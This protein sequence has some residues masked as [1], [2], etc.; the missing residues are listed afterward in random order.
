MILIYEPAHA[1]RYKNFRFLHETEE[2]CHIIYF[3]VFLFP[4]SEENLINDVIKC[5]HYNDKFY[6]VIILKLN[7]LK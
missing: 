4:K 3:L 6:Y 7:V 2:K 1:K 5:C